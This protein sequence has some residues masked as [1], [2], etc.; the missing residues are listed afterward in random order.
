MKLSTFFILSDV[1][2]LVRL[3]GKFDIDHSQE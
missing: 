2:S 3:Q 1:I